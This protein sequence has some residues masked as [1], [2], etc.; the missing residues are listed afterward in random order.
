MKYLRIQYTILETIMIEDGATPD[1][2]ED[3]IDADM[4]DKGI[5]NMV[6]EYEWHVSD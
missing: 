4:W 6:H 1:E 3:L 5:V 2:I